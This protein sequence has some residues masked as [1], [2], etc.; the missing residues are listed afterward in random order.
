MK[1]KKKKSSLLSFSVSEDAVH[2]H[3]RP[4]TSHEVLEFEDEQQRTDSVQEQLL[5]ELE[6]LSDSGLYIN[7]ILCTRL[8]LYEL[9]LSMTFV[10]QV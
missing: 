10:N 9:Y 4:S 7:T 2:L 1:K 6:F 5:A 3:S 8:G